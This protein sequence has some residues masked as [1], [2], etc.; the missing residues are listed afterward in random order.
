MKKIKKED[1]I[2]ML[3]ALVDIKDWLWNNGLITTSAYRTAK[4]AIEKSL[5]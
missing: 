2:N 5:K 3:D 4:E 1:A